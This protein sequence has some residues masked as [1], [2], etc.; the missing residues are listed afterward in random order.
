MDFDQYAES[1]TDRVD[2]AMAGCGLHH[3]FFLK[4]KAEKLL[5]VLG[6]IGDPRQMTILDVGSGVGLMETQLIGHVRRLFG[7]DVASDA[8][9]AS[10]QQVQGAAFLTYDGL[11]LPFSD[12]AFDA[13]FAICVLH[14]VAPGDWQTV[15]AEMTRVVRP[16]GAVIVFEHNPWNPVTRLVVSRCEFDRDATLLPAPAVKR[17]LRGATGAPSKGQFLFFFPWQGRIWRTLEKGLGWLPLGAQYVA[18]ARR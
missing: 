17:L 3:D 4:A 16:G 9:R 6:R 10:A 13:V 2:E 15:V 8:V 7:V 14:H 11:R 18:H 5:E 12:H 1:Y